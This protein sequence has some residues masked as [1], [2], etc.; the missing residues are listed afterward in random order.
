MPATDKPVQAG[1]QKRKPLDTYDVY[2][3]QS[4]TTGIFD[5]T[6]GAATGVV[7]ASAPTGSVCYAAN[8]L[9]GRG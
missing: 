8:A 5:L 1:I 7:L 9:V 6:Y 2:P 4:S 3:G